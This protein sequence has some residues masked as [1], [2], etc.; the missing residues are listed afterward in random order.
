M[1]VVL[2]NRVNKRLLSSKSVRDPCFLWEVVVGLFEY[3]AGWRETVPGVSA[4]DSGVPRTCTSG[5]DKD[6]CFLGDF[7]YG[8]RAE[9][10]SFG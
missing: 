1:R 8:G 5:L 7:I 4:V 10:R 2:R 9:M 6:G 3:S